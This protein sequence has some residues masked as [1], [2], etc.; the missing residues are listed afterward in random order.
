MLKHFKGLLPAWGNYFPEENRLSVLIA[1]VDMVE[2][3]L[4][5]S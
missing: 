1:F 5:L 3:A 4:I 2:T